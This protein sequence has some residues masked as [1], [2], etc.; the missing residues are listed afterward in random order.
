MTRARYLICRYATTSSV[1]QKFGS[2]SLIPRLSRSTGSNNSCSRNMRKSGINTAPLCVT[3]HR[4]EMEA[5]KDVN[6]NLRD[7]SRISREPSRFDFSAESLRGI[8]PCEGCGL[9]SRHFSRRTALSAHYDTNRPTLK[10]EAVGFLDI[11]KRATRAMNYRDTKPRSKIEQSPGI[12]AAQLHT[13]R[14]A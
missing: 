3:S 14:F 13:T 9:G 2:D 4:G 8:G 10:V 12:P 5:I 11:S 7:V 1:F 6:R